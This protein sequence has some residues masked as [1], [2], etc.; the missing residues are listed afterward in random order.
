[1]M[2]VML[3]VNYLNSIVLKREELRFLYDIY[4]AF[5]TRVHPKVLKLNFA[6]GLYVHSV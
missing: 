3:K 5:L 4:S 2:A 6:E 1:M